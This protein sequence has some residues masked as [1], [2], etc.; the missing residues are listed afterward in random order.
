MTMSIL[1]KFNE[2]KIEN[3]SR[4]D[5]ED[6]RYCEMQEQAYNETL[7]LYKD[8]LG[9]LINLYNKQLKTMHKTDNR[10][11][12]SYDLYVSDYT[13]D[14]GVGKVF[15]EILKLKKKFIGRVCC[16]FENKYKITINSD[17]ICNKYK[18]VEIS[19][20][21]RK[22]NDGTYNNNLIEYKELNYNMILDEIF[23]QLEGFSFEEKAVDEMKNNLQ[24]LLKWQIKDG[25][26]KIAKNKVTIPNFF[27]IDSFD[28]NFGNYKVDYSQREKFHTLLTAISNY[29]EN[30]T[31]T[32]Y[33]DFI[34]ILQ[35]K[36]DDDVFKEHS[37]MCSKAESIKLYKNGKVDIKFISS[38]CAK[39]FL[40]VYCN[41]I[42][43]S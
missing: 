3:V 22:N 18:D 10:K 29:E 9:K 17:I 19:Y 11:L 12:D 30:T 26:I 23:M 7:S 6:R 1:N 43:V 27:Y 15:E 37:L 40:K 16:H 24:N 39:E 42:P 2:V 38:E 41:Y 34:Y 33:K 32:I 31:H 14:F 36:Q 21:K 28:K 13:N 4:I 35:N 5:E 8:I 25:K 20:G